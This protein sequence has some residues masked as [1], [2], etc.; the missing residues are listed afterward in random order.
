MAVCMLVMLLLGGDAAA[1]EADS[2]AESERREERREVEM[3]VLWY[4]ML[5]GLDKERSRAGGMEMLA[6]QTSPGVVSISANLL[7]RV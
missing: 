7:L 2:R 6:P 1:E 3:L 4:R 5:L